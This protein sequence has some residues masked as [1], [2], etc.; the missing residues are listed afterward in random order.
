MEQRLNPFSDVSTCIK[1]GSTSLPSHGHI[2]TRYCAGGKEPEERPEESHDPMTQI[3]TVFSKV[4]SVHNQ[5]GAPLVPS[6]LNIC[7]GIGEEHLHKTCSGCGYEWLT[8][9]KDAEGK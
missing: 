6:R 4:A 3:A 5:V 9:T 8:E 1:C 7:A 2:G